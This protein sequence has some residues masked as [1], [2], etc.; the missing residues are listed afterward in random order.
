VPGQLALSPDAPAPDQG[1]PPPA[2][3]SLVNLFQHI[4]E[5]LLSSGNLE[6]M[7]SKV[8]GVAM[9]S[10][11]AERGFICLCDEEAENVLPKAAQAKGLAQ[12]ESMTISRSIAREAIR[13]R[14][15][16]LVDDAPADRRFALAGSV[17]SMEI[18]AAMCAPLYHAGRV[19]GLIYVDTRDE[20]NT[21]AAGDLELLAA[22]GVL[23]AVGIL[24][25]RLRDEVDRE[26]AVFAR[27]S[28]YSS[29]RVVEQIVASIDSPDGTM[30]AA[31]REVSVLFADLSDFTTIAES[32]QP[33]EV[34]SMLNC[35][36]E[37]LT[38][39]IFQFDG[40]LDK[41]L[42]DG[43]LAVFGAPV[44]QGDHADRAVSAAILMRQLLEECK[45]T[46]P[47][48]EP[49]SM[50]IGVNSGAVVAGDIGSPV[51]KDYTV[52]GD[53]VNVASRLQ[54]SVARPGQVVIGQTTYELC[55]HGF[56]CEPLPEIRLKGKQ[57]TV[58][59]YLVV[60]QRLDTI[61]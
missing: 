17:M 29:P 46:G 23:T 35:A 49:L 5:V 39:A 56:E 58:R 12:G 1:L 47:Q 11:P 22:L 45:L 24:Q 8:L 57:Q 53:V 60:G 51:R 43:L 25:A 20:G 10:L 7:L 28:R 59:P 40:T 31:Q 32:W 9:D 16:L 6:D 3:F 14:Q 15:A 26:K 34:V 37:H 54:S 44:P 13:S 33:V 27:L 30:L 38:R 41:F 50:R 36:F 4:G 55:K 42:G 21:F 18:R 52:V 19:E 48:G 2:E 61:G